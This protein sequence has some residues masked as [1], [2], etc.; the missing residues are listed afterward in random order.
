M[1]EPLFGTIQWQ[2]LRAL[3]LDALQDPGLQQ[4]HNL[5][6]HETTRLLAFLGENW[7]HQCPR[8]VELASMEQALR[9]EIRDIQ[10]RLEYEK[11]KTA[12]VAATMTYS[13]SLEDIE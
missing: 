7:G 5:D 12:E 9:R 2:R 1:T 8:Q 3:L 4:K 11:Q 10:Q 13:T 6:P